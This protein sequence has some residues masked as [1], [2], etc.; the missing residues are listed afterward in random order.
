MFCFLFFVTP[1]LG[2][3]KTEVVTGGGGGDGDVQY[4]AWKMPTPSAPLFLLSASRRQQ[5]AA[6]EPNVR[7][8][9]Q[10]QRDGVES[11]GDE[12]AVEG[13]VAA[14]KE[15]V[16]AVIGYRHRVVDQLNELNSDVRI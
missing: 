16:H 5:V 2:V 4:G 13:G 12:V 11:A 15:D 14:A 7:G 6:K 8:E 3:R 10:A 9:H 1:I